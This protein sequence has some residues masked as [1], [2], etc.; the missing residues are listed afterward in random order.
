[1]VEVILL[2]WLESLVLGLLTLKDHKP[3]PVEHCQV[4]EPLAKVCIVFEDDTIW[5]HRLEFRD[6][7]ALEVPLELYASTDHVERDSCLS[8]LSSRAPI[9]PSGTQFLGGFFVCFLWKFW[10]AL[11]VAVP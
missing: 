6:E 5:K 1:M 10:T 7:I 8:R 4:G 11:T 9:H 2:I 3:I